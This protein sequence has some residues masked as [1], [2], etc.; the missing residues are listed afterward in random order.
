LL[1]PEIEG[2]T[3][4][5]S[6][7]GQDGE[8]PKALHKRLKTE[9]LFALVHDGDI[10]CYDYYRDGKLV[11]EYNSRPDYFEK[12][13]PKKRR[14]LA[15]RPELLLPLLR[16]PSDLGEL[17]NI[18][19]SEPEDDLFDANSRLT[20]FGELL[21]LPNCTTCYDYLMGDEEDEAIERRAEFVH[22]PDL[23][24]EKAARASAR[25][26]LRAETGRMQTEGLLSFEQSPSPLPPAAD[27]A[28]IGFVT[29]DR[30]MTFRAIERPLYRIAPPFEEGPKPLG[31]VAVP[32]RPV[33]LSPSGRFLAMINERIEVWDRE[34]R[35]R[36]AA[37]QSEP[38]VNAVCF[39][40]EEKG[41][42]AGGRRLEV[43]SLPDG[44]L[45]RTIEVSAGHAM[46]LYPAGPLLVLVSGRATVQVVDLDAGHVVR[47]F[48]L[49]SRQDL[50]AFEKMQ[51]AL[52]SAAAEKARQ[53]AHRKVASASGGTPEFAEW[54]AA[55]AA[56]A[57]EPLTAEQPEAFLFSPDGRYLICGTNKAAWV[58]RWRSLLASGVETPPAVYRYRSESKASEMPMAFMF[59][60]DF[61]AGV[62]ALAYDADTNCALL[63][64]GDGVVRKMDLASGEVS[65][66]LTVPGG[67]RI[68]SMAL[69]SDG[70]LLCT[71]DVSMHD[72]QNRMT[73]LMG[74]SP[75]AAAV[76]DE[77]R[78]DRMMIWDYRK[79]RLDLRN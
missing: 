12:V 23:A 10:F 9:V 40:A 8:V 75:V 17:G 42:V 7:R 73:A 1:A 4:I 45:V 69:S 51:L 41:L 27:P 70:S 31:I 36:I 6:S 24:P 37:M 67:N 44:N 13:S 57:A 59:P 56:Q 79:L 76:Q 47:K 14:S 63:G 65:T 30:D 19:H 60:T 64:C 77:E 16:D 62:G 5:Y 18:L 46:A 48:F 49:D 35:T 74:G 26:A 3:A 55:L 2:W 71:V 39:L 58:F 15:G 29:A 43:F 53:Q 66:L 72:L 22:I 52:M 50:G 68:Q 21:G 33:V 32:R 28:G 61:S 25:G 38:P 78:R 11:D 54:E 20:Q 34:A